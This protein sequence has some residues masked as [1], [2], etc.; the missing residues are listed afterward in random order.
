MG[1]W[2]WQC[3]A[4]ARYTGTEAVDEDAKVYGT[5]FLKVSRRED[6]VLVYERVDPTHVLLTD[7]PSA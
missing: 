6:G 4:C 5:G 3:E 7:D 1:T 2:H